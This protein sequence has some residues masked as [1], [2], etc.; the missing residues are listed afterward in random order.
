MT[1]SLADTA[2]DTGVDTRVDTAQP[3]TDP[4]PPEL[5]D[6]VRADADRVD[7]GSADL[8]PLLRRLAAEGLAD[9]GAPG[10]P[11]TLLEQADV[12][13]AIARSC[14][15]SA[16]T[17]W[18]HRMTVQYLALRPVG[19][20]R[21]F[22][23]AV[24]RAERL[25]STAMAGA[26][27]DLAGIAELS[28]TF[29][30]APGGVV[31]DGV[32]PWASNLY[33]DAVVVTAARNPA[34]GDRL[35]V[36]VPVS[37]PGLEVALTQDLLALG[38]T[39]SGSLRLHGVEVPSDHVLT[40]DLPAFLRQVRPVFLVLQSA[41]CLGLAAAS[42]EASPQ[43]V[44]VLATFA[45]E[46]DH[47]LDRLARLRARLAELA[48]CAGTPGQP[49]PRAYLELRL[50]AGHLARAATELELCLTGGRGYVATSPTA[51]RV[52]EALFL[53][54]QSPTEGQLRW[55]LARSD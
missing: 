49:G 55:E 36:A 47:Q 21:E 43:P 46:L 11:G 51:R 25:G 9:L 42:L 33:D 17:L 30:P 45:D 3:G 44:G 35:V 19:P 24:R 40:G 27:R 6:A 41:F 20:L 16:F 32:V 1:A 10:S 26:F 34:T 5:A 48:R 37:S 53:P 8:R 13:E 4:L 7:R 52:R 38:S 29:R 22:G 2:I 18:A 15:T 31:L 39:R 28:V 54:V 14:M 23:A 50:G 12:V